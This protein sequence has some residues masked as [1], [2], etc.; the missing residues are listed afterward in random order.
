MKNANGPVRLIA[1]VL[2]ELGKAHLDES[3]AWIAVLWSSHDFVK[4]G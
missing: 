2:S 1:I 3:H 4:P